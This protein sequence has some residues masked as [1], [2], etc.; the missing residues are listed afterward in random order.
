MKNNM[1]NQNVVASSGFQPSNQ[2]YQPQ[3]SYPPPG[4]YPPQNMM[5][6]GMHQPPYGGMPHMQG[7]HMMPPGRMGS[8]GYPPA[9][10]MQ[11]SD[12]GNYH[13]QQ[14]PAPNYS[15]LDPII[16]TEKK[17]SMAKDLLKSTNEKITEVYKKLY[18]GKIPSEVKDNIIERILKACGTVESWK[19]AID[20]SGTPKS[21]GYVEF[22][23]VEGAIVCMKIVN[24]LQVGQSKLV[25]SFF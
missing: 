8:S 1:Y 13:S 25:V 17:E 3:G 21:F 20:A 14:Q 23:E 18:I 22:E 11:H 7:S 6:G 24:G 15:F 16:P 4:G 2:N 10:G 19:R 5:H 12:Y 9:G